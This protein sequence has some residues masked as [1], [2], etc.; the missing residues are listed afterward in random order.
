MIIPYKITFFDTFIN[1]KREIASVFPRMPQIKRSSL[2][3]GREDRDAK[4]C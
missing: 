4:G 2:A 3:V 1:E